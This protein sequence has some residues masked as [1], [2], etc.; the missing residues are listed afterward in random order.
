MTVDRRRLVSIVVPVYDSPSLE[1]LTVAIDAVFRDA[2]DD[3]E[4]VFVDDASPNERVWPALERL[5]RRSSSV[6]ALQLTRNFGQQPATLCGLREARGDVVIT[7]DDDLQHDPADLPLLLSRADHDIVIAQFE[8]K[9]HGLLRRLASRAKGFFDE[10]LIGKPKGL[11]LSSFRLLSRTT[12]EGILSIRTPNPFLPA[13]MFHV[14][15]DVVGVPVRHAPRAGGRSG[16]T[17]RKLLRLFSNLVIN[18]SSLLLRG[19]AAAG[20]LFAFSSFVLAAIVIYRKLADKVAVQGWT[21][22]MAAVL[23]TGGLLLVS[24]GIMGEYLIRII[25]SAEARPTYFVRRRAAAS[26]AD[27]RVDDT[28]SVLSAQ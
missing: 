6:R 24:V 26:E 27:D 13:L 19:V 4:I 7:M 11:Q 3:Y 16:Y 14:S 20:I 25:Q 17:P 5:A 12:V 1:A 28:L 8:R 23:L 15:K 2:A 18:N 10:I 9:E 22:L 21:S